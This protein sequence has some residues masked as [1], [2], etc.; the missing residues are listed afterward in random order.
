[1]KDNIKRDVLQLACTGASWAQL[2]WSVMVNW[3]I[4]MHIILE[5]Y[6][7]SFQIVVLAIAKQERGVGWI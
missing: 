4:T 7:R 1:M 3:R 6:N 2:T 5:Q